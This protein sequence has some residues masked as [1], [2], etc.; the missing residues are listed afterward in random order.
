ME[1]DIRLGD[2]QTVEIIASDLVLYNPDRLTA[3]A[4]AARRALVHDYDGDRLTINYGGDYPAGVRISGR[5]EIADLTAG[6]AE[7]TGE[8]T[9][10]GNAEIKGAMT[11]DGNAEIKGAMTVDG[12][13]EIKGNLKLD[14]RL[15]SAVVLRLVGEPWAGDGKAIG[16]LTQDV[17]LSNIDI[18]PHSSGNALSAV[19]G[20][21]LVLNRG[22]EFTGGVRIEGQVELGQVAATNYQLKIKGWDL[23]LDAPERRPNT[24]PALP[25]RALVHDS[26]D[27]L[28]IN[29]ACDYAG[30]VTIAG[31]VAF[32][33]D[34]T[35]EGRLRVLNPNAG[36]PLSLKYLD[37]GQLLAALNGQVGDLQK[38]VMEL[39]AK[40]NH[41]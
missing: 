4:S 23:I 30:G 16:L 32:P 25:R 9:V 1:T 10:D 28:T 36:G 3:S 22:G 15:D 40:I 29:Y 34:V 35:V 14:G 39:E 26:G 6:N 13:A 24:D 5:T 11:V 21:M 17:M 20:D 12:N 27:K 8:I 31:A 2:E 33:G 41:Q 19:A 18:Q 38:K 7:I 37:V